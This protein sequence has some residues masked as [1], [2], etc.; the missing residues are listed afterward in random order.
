MQCNIWSSQDA[1]FAAWNSDCSCLCACD[2]LKSRF[3]DTSQCELQEVESSMAVLACVVLVEILQAIACRGLRWLMPLWRA[4]YASQLEASKMLLLAVAQVCAPLSPVCGLLA[5]KWLWSEQ[6]LP[7]QLGA[8]GAIRFRLQ[9]VDISFYKYAI[10]IIF[11]WCCLRWL[12]IIPE[13][14]LICRRSHATSFMLW[15]QYASVASVVAVSIAFQPFAPCLPCVGFVGALIWYWAVKAVIARGAV[16][17][18][19]GTPVRLALLAARRFAS[20]LWA[21]SFLGCCFVAWAVWYPSDTDT[22]GIVEGMCGP[23]FPVSV[24]A[25]MLLALPFLLWLCR[26]ILWLLCGIGS[27]PG[28]GRPLVRNPRTDGG[29]WRPQKVPMSRINFHEAWLVMRH[30]S[31]L[32]SYGLSDHPDYQ[33]LLKLLLPD[34]P[35]VTLAEKP[36]ETAYLGRSIDMTCSRAVVHESAPRRAQLPP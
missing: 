22:Q 35:Q 8:S 26:R 27:P 21:A 2:L 29:S 1:S 31:I 6:V 17:V 4:A 32:S 18:R 15:K 25:S 24:L 3:P 11:V 10:P 20:F 14:L 23:A 12:A 9:Q 7:L 33:P 30:R 5:L 16:T 13:A 34:R 28:T 36:R 19:F